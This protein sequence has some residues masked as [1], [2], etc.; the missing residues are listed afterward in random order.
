M[1]TIGVG[2]Y[3]WENAMKNPPRISE[4][5]NKIPIINIKKLLIYLNLPD[6]SS[7]QNTFAPILNLYRYG[8]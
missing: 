6:T 8:S 1:L 7:E 2:G 5:K 4:K 3:K